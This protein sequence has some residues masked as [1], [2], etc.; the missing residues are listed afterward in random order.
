MLRGEEVLKV[1]SLVH[2]ASR[3]ET[4]AV[5]SGRQVPSISIDGGYGN[6]LGP[7]VAVKLAYRFT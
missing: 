1:S 7:S 6:V 5:C 4:L 3:K 2:S